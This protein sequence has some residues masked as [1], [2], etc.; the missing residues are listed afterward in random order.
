MGSFTCLRSVRTLFEFR[1]Q[2]VHPKNINIGWK[3]EKYLC[4]I[5]IWRTES[6]IQ[7]RFSHLCIC[8]K[9][10]CGGRRWSVKDRVLWNSRV[11]RITPGFLLRFALSYKRHVASLGTS[12]VSTR[13]SSLDSL[14]GIIFHSRGNDSRVLTVPLNQ[15]CAYRTDFHSN[16]SY[17]TLQRKWYNHCPYHS[18]F[19]MLVSSQLAINVFTA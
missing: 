16:G 6:L 1:L 14:S 11:L 18:V 3:L 8:F 7:R 9:M 19:L 13:V 12:L 2:S 17:Q 4:P 10:R 5:Q 15:T